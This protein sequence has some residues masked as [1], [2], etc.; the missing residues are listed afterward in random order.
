MEDI[1]QILPFHL[2]F[3]L[4]AFCDAGQV[5]FQLPA[6]FPFPLDDPQFLGHPLENGIALDNRYLGLDVITAGPGNRPG[7]KPFHSGLFFKFY[8]AGGGIKGIRGPQNG[9]KGAKKT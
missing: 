2:N 8:T 3:G 9:E 6:L 1:C 4:K 7:I 5:L